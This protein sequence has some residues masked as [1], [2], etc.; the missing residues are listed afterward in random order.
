MSTSVWFRL[1]FI[2]FFFKQ[3]TAYEL[4]ISDWSS[5]VCSSDLHRHREK[6]R[7]ET[8]AVDEAVICLLTFHDSRQIKRPSPQDHCNQ[9]EANGNFIADHLRGSAHR[10]IERIFGIGCPASDDHA[11]DAQGTDRKN[12]EQ[13]HIDVGQNNACTERNNCPGDLRNGESDDRRN[14]EQGPIGRRWNDGFL[15]EYL[16]AISNTLKQTKRQI[17]RAHV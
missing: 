14:Q 9:D 15:K 4:R 16:R 12:I 2:F 7:V 6:Q 17:G 8:M 13:A 1:V 5:D 10:R 11:V 3:K